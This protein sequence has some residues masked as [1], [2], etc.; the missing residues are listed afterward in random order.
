MVII[1]VHSESEERTSPSGVIPI[2]VLK[3][4][5]TIVEISVLVFSFYY[6]KLILN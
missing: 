6:H 4:E 3:E 1:A 2:E 5:S